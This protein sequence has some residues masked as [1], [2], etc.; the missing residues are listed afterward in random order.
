[1]RAH[2]GEPGLSR[3][4]IAATHHMSARTLDRLFAGQPWS[5]SGLIRH[6]RL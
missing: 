2:L 5:V 6:E 3:S 1:V 4:S